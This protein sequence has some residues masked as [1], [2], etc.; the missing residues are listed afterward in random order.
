MKN[1]KEFKNVVRKKNTNFLKK[2]FYI[3]IVILFSDFNDKNTEVIRWFFS[4]I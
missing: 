3:F 4:V 2:I 1:R